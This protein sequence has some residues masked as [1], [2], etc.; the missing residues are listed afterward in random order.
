[1]H[2][3]L[4]TLYPV[5]GCE[6]PL[7]WLTR[8]AVGTVVARTHGWI[9]FPALYGLDLFAIFCFRCVN[10]HRPKSL[11]TVKFL[12]G[13]RVNYTLHSSSPLTVEYYGRAEGLICCDYIG[14]VH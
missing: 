3:S 13:A 7:I 10:N 14:R 1:M 9:Y 2:R 4:G 12:T 5:M 11:L 8:A 6:V